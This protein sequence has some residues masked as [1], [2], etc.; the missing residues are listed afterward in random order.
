LR[1]YL[2]ALGLFDPTLDSVDRD[3][4]A[5]VR[6]DPARLVIISNVGAKD[7]LAAPGDLGLCLLRDTVYAAVQ[8]SVN[9]DSLLHHGI[10]C[11]GHARRTEKR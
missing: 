11:V 4:V 9:D 2:L 8:R 3:L 10:G 5:F 6:V 7:S 1:T